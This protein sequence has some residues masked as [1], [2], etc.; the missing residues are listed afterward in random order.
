MQRVMEAKL[1][2][3]AVKTSN[4]YLNYSHN[5]AQLRSIFH[6]LVTLAVAKCTLPENTF[7]SNKKNAPKNCKSSTSVLKFG[8]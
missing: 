6:I 7:H 1:H 8:W 4:I 5:F 2:C 3:A